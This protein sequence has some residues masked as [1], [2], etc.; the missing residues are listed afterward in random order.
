MSKLKL[1]DVVA[2]I[3]E[4]LD[5]F[6]SLE[7]QRIVRAALTLLGDEA[8]TPAPNGKSGADEDTG[9]DIK[10]LSGQAK[11]WMKQNHISEAVLQHVFHISN[12]KAEVIASEI[13]GKDGKAKTVN[14]YILQ[15]ISSFL[16]SGD[17]K[18][19]DK[20]ARVLCSKSGVLN[21]TN[22]S[23]YIKDGIG[24]KLTGSKDTGWVL[25]TPGLKHGASLI[26]ELT[27]TTKE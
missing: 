15:G 13:P 11:I 1:T 10:E 27:N 6:D 22:H 20:A 18:F 5:P 26:K 9:G 12:G 17:S 7:R 19:E 2:N 3:V 23:A 21:G 8:G 16:I 4:L 14:A 25:T 24:N